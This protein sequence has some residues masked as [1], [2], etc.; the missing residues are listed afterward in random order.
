[1]SW[2]RILDERFKCNQK[3]INIFP[4]LLIPIIRIL[5]Q[6]FWR[7]LLF[8]CLPAHVSV[9]YEFIQLINVT[10]S[11]GQQILRSIFIRQLKLHIDYTFTQAYHKLRIISFW[12]WSLR[13]LTWIQMEWK[14]KGWT[15][16]H[17]SIEAKTIFFFC[18]ALHTFVLFAVNLESLCNQRVMSVFHS[19]IQFLILSFLDSVKLHAIERLNKRLDLLCMSMSRS[20]YLNQFNWYKTSLIRNQLKYFNVFLLIKIIRI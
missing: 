6:I 10:F 16:K 17:A 2:S 7:C 12:N 3:W 11:I 20:I 8:D 14:T 19:D 4:Y 5:L 1:M 18:E 15:T 9:R 13:R